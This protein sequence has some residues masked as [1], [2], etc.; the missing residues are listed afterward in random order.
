MA[1]LEAATKKSLN[2][3]W[4]VWWVEAMEKRQGRALGSDVLREWQGLASF[5]CH[6]R[7]HTEE[8]RA[9]TWWYL[10]KNLPGK[11]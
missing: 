9:G 11:R 10:G 7:G 6:L 5:K 4:R 3:S 8:M 1:I 2:E